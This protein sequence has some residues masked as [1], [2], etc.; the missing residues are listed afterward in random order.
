MGA[1]LTRTSSGFMMSQPFLDNYGYDYLKTLH[2]H[3]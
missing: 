2:T 1:A 3:V